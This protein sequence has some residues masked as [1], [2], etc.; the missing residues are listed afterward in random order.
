V[1]VRK[2]S[3]TAMQTARTQIESLEWH[4]LP[5]I[6][7]PGTRFPGRAAFEACGRSRAWSLSRDRPGCDMLS[8]FACF[9]GEADTAACGLGR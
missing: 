9:G 7:R 1:V 8:I 3:A 4:N 2:I 5:R 6:G